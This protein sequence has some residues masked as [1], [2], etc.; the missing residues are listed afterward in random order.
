M[1]GG[2][3]LDRGRLNDYLHAGRWR[4]L[5]D[6]PGG[7]TQSGGGAHQEVGVT[8]VDRGDGVI[9]N[10]QRGGRQAGRHL[11]RGHGHGISERYGSIIERYRS[12]GQ[13]YWEDTRRASHR[14]RESYRRAKQGRVD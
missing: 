6:A 8:T 10:A 3:D 11:P 5:G 7:S 13:L 14:C 4:T 1:Q 9:A 2:D 12:A